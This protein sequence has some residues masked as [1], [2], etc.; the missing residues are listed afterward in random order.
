MEKAKL[1]VS[2]NLLA[3]GVFFTAYVGMIPL[4]ILAGYILLR[5]ENKWLKKSAVKALIINAAFTVLS[6]AITF[7]A[8]GPSILQDMFYMFNSY[9]DSFSSFMRGFSYFTSILR[10]LLG[11]IN[12]LVCLGFGFLALTNKNSAKTESLDAVA[13]KYL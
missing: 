13:E 7:L 2:V 4:I 5:E 10:T 9:S 1:G 8:S 6:A 3:A 11:D 12:M